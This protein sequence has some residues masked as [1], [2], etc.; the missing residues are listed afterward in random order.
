[1][2]RPITRALIAALSSHGTSF[3]AEFRQLGRDVTTVRRWGHLPVDVENL[4][5]GADIEGPADGGRF[6][7]P[8]DAVRP[9]GASVGIAEK[10]II[11]TQLLREFPVLLQRIDA[12]GE[13]YDVEGSDLVGALTERLALRR[14]TGAEG[15]CKPHENDRLLAAIIPKPVG[16]SVGA[17]HLEI[18]RRIAGLEHRRFCVGGALP[19]VNCRRPDHRQKSQHDRDSS[20]HLPTSTIENRR[21]YNPGP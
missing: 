6:R 18:G 8:G 14:S 1:M 16:A 11:D 5:V 2:V 17:A 9:R 13:E 19:R 15:A 4:A 7:I 21:Q 3:D 12:G 20:H 10:R